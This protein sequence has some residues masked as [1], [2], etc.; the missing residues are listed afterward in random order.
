M[1]NPLIQAHKPLRTVRQNGTIV[2]GEPPRIRGWRVVDVRPLGD[3]TS[4]YEYVYAP[5]GIHLLWKLWE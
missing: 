2:V 3:L 1:R 4:E 5:V